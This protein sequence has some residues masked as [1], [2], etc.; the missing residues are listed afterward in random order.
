MFFYFLMFFLL[1]LTIWQVFSTW[2]FFGTLIYFTII[3]VDINK[4][5]KFGVFLLLLEDFL[6]Y[7][8]FGLSLAY[9]VPILLFSPKIKILFR[10][11]SIIPQTLIFLFSF[12]I[13]Y[14]LLKTIN[15]GYFALSQSTIKII[16]S[17][18][19]ILIISLKI[20]GFLGMRGNRS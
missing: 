6:V 3:L 12:G 18:L 15:N 11:G 13:Y 7:G 5:P 10:E 20:R 16:L 19:I 4:I 14:L 9:L 8:V 17:N 2:S 1:D